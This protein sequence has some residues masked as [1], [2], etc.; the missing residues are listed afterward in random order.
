MQNYKKIV[1]SLFLSLC[2]TWA[3]ADEN[4][5]TINITGPEEQTDNAITENRAQIQRPTQVNQAPRQRVIPQRVAPIAQATQAVRAPQAQAQTVIQQNA[6]APATIQQAANVQTPLDN[7]PTRQAN[8]NTPEFSQYTVKAQDNIWSIASRFTPISGAVNE[9][10]VLASIYR[11]NPDAF[12]NNNVNQL[13]RVILNIPPL[14]EIAKESAEEGSLLLQRGTLRLKALDN[15]NAIVPERVNNQSTVVDDKLLTK[16]ETALESNDKQITIDNSKA[17]GFEIPKYVARETQMKELKR[18]VDLNQNTFYEDDD[19]SLGDSQ[20]STL[21]AQNDP[22][23]SQEDKSKYKDAKPLEAKDLDISAVKELLANTQE[24]F[25]KQSEKLD[26]K[27]DMSVLRAE[28]VAKSSASSIA[29]EEVVKV[30]SHYES[31]IANLQQSNAEL[32]ASISKFNKQVDQIRAISIT[33]ADKL[34]E[35]ETQYIGMTESTDE[36]I[37]QGPLMW[38]LLGVG[39]LSLS[40]AIVFFILK[41]KN[42]KHDDNSDEYMTDDDLAS[43]QLLTTGIVNK[44]EMEKA[45]EEAKNT[46]DGEDDIKESE[47]TAQSDD[48]QKKE[49]NKEQ[50][51]FEMNDKKANEAPNYDI[52]P[53]R[54]H[55]EDQLI[56]PNN[57]DGD[58]DPHEE[59]DAESTTQQEAQKA[60]DDAAKEKSK[61]AANSE[62]DVMAA[63]SAALNEEKDNSSVVDLKDDEENTKAREDELAASWAKAL[64][65]QDNS[66]NNADEKSAD[67]ALADAWAKALDEGTADEG[68]QSKKDSALDADNS[69]SASADTN[70]TADDEIVLSKLDAIKDSDDEMSHDERELASK[71]A[72]MSTNNQ[73]DISNL[74][75][76]DK[77]AQDTSFDE[78]L[79]DKK[80]QDSSIIDDINDT[81]FDQNTT[82]DELEALLANAPTLDSNDSANSSLN[83]F[84]SDVNTD[85]DTQLN[86]DIVSN[87]NTDADANINT[88]LD[89]QLNQDIV[90][91]LNTDA[92]TNTDTNINSDIDFDSISDDIKDSVSESILN[93]SLKDSETQ[94][95]DSYDL[96]ELEKA[97]NNS[98]DSVMLSDEAK[99]L[100]NA[101][102]DTK[103]DVKVIGDSIDF[104]SILDDATKQS[105]DAKNLDTINDVSDLSDANNTIDYQDLKHSVD[106]DTNIKS[107]DTSYDT[108]I[109][110][111]NTKEKA[112]LDEAILDGSKTDDTQIDATKIDDI[113]VDKTLEDTIDSV[114]DNNES[115]SNTTLEKESQEPLNKS[116][117]FDDYVLNNTDNTQDKVSWEIPDNDFDITASKDPIKLHNDID[118]SQISGNEDESMLT[119][120]LSS[121]TDDKSVSLNKAQAQSLSDKDLSN[122][123]SDY[124]HDDSL[125]NIKDLSLGDENKNLD[126]N[127][128]YLSDDD[129]T[130]MLSDN[131]LKNETLNDIKIDTDNLHDASLDK[132]TDIRSFDK[133]SSIDEKSFSLDNTNDESQTSFNVDESAD[134]KKDEQDFNRSYQNVNASE[135]TNISSKLHQKLTD[136]LNLAQLFFETGDTDEAL[137][138]VDKVREQGSPDLVQIADDLK[139]RYA[140]N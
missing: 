21:N 62:D 116:K 82:Q 112:S 120:M 114:Q 6:Q 137:S 51:Q 81:S 68:T 92:D 96:K 13:R 24:Q 53:D 67:E 127:A 71:M 59:D 76:D 28:T 41:S 107:Q 31:V 25:V 104:N 15:N 140:D 108:D 99:A 27:I 26:K 83:D 85:L 11:Y 139:S 95:N 111:S 50:N 4:T 16:I 73:D 103:D 105:L 121:D 44:E 36:S 101:M 1:L 9:F 8:T 136:E 39:I 135:N 84:V 17:T 14:S 106:L 12:S 49:E 122:M 89:T 2:S 34:T 54:S 133:D 126:I 134:Y 97:F 131:D 45:Q 48:A 37:P 35:L 46:T 87:L 117:S 30:L 118:L 43:E 23:N 52:N 57:I 86:Q 80:V 138:I 63:W 79:H 33:N 129:L 102:T 65:E 3:I 61:K 69:G 110:T 91:N 125:D 98:D 20:G 72:S 32:R 60:W 19:G 90:S 58:D 22:A 124:A 5:F 119:N 78:I 64:D 29:K 18:A 123:I 70:K 75:D 40:L 130:K 56:V 10:Q 38:I 42:K 7:A 74:I 100:H 109:K 55:Y 115:F 47:D 66:S 88:D 77:K 128:S 132:S 94:S 113:N 93:D